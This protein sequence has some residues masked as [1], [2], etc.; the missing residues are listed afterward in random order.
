MKSKRNILIALLL[1]MLGGMSG[2]KAQDVSI[3][4]FDGLRPLLEKKNDTIYVINFWATWCKPCVEELPFFEQL[5]QTKFDTP[6][7]IILVSLDFKSQLKAKLIPFVK[8]HPQLPEVILLSDPDSNKWIP[9][10][11]KDWGG[12]IPVTLVYQGSK[13]KFKDDAFENFDD[14]MQFLQS[15]LKS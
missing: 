7:R 3:A 10:V 5:A 1:I 8:A 14:L 9:E 2:L 6:V 11:D 13:R 15:F 4:N 12:A